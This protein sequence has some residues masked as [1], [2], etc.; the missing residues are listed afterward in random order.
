MRRRLKARFHNGFLIGLLWG[1]MMM[2]GIGLMV[3]ALWIGQTR[4]GLTY[5]IPGAAY[6]A[7]F[8]WANREVIPWT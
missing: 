8:A 4:M 2:V 1:A 6:I 5:I 7:L 3:M